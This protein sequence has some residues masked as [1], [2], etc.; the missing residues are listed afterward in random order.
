MTRSCEAHNETTQEGDLIIDGGNEWFQNSI[1]RSEALK[2]K[3]ILF[4][5][6][7]ISGGEE[8]AR[9]GPSLMPGGPKEAY[10]MMEPIITKCSAQVSNLSV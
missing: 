2:E 4:M 3:K 6:M 8:G 10:D 1:R 9:K 7:G 5:G